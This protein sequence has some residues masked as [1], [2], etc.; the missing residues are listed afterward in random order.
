M[1]A[2]RVTADIANWGGDFRL[3]P[4][5][6]SLMKFRFRLIFYGISVAECRRVSVVSFATAV[7]TTLNYCTSETPDS[8]K[9]GTDAASAAAP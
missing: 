4:K 3:S 1:S 8:K 7:S 9:S 6:A 5:V 2:H